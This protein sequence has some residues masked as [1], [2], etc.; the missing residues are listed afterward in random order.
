MLSVMPFHWASIFIFFCLLITESCLSANSA[1]L[2]SS[3]PKSFTSL[4]PPTVSPNHPA[5]FSLSVIN[6]SM[7][8]FRFFAKCFII[9]AFTGIK[10]KYHECHSVIQD[11]KPDD[12]TYHA[13]CLGDDKKH[14][15][16]CNRSHVAYIHIYVI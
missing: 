8:L 3:I 2:F 1:L 4:T 14:T 11:K 7:I 10:R 6:S 12:S 5:Y 13:E 15:L 16:I 9:T